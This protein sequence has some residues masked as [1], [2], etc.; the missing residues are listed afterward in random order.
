[1]LTYS[2]HGPRTGL[3]IAA[4]SCSTRRVDAGVTWVIDEKGATATAAPQGEVTPEMVKIAKKFKLQPV[5]SV[6]T[7]QFVAP[8]CLAG[9]P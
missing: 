5:S 6:S 4:T 8:S 3:T 9:P 7:A 2:D 1:M